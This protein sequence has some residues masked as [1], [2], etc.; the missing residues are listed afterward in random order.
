MLLV[1]AMGIFVMWYRAKSIM[2]KRGRESV[3]GTNKAVIELAAAML[4][5]LDMDDLDSKVL[6]EKQIQ[7]R[8]AAVQGGCISYS[9]SILTEDR[10]ADTSVVEW[11][12]KDRWWIAATVVFVA[13]TSFVWILGIWVAILFAGPMFGLITA[14][15]FGSTWKSKGLFVLCWTVIGSMAAITFMHFYPG[16]YLR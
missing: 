2:L 4:K 7:H 16:Y 12:R 15:L 10:L 3:A 9:C 11:L 5:E 6:T 14:L 1:W 8:I 13:A